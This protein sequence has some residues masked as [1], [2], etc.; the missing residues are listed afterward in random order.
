MIRRIDIRFISEPEMRQPGIGDWWFTPDTL[1]IRAVESHD[2]EAFLV[3]LHELV[4]AWLCRANGIEQQAVDA[5]D[6]LFETESHPN[7]AEPGDDPRAPYR[8]E[9]R[10]AMLLEMLM[11]NFLGLSSYGTVR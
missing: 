4:E 6:V 9:H 2:D 11:A 8:L 3:A 7:E 10:K 1:H 5:F